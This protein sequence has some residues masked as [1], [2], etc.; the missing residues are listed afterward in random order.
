M[1]EGFWM[2]KTCLRGLAPSLV[3]LFGV[4]SVQA[5]PLLPGNVIIKDDGVAVPGLSYV[6]GGGPGGWNLTVFDTGTAP[7]FSFTLLVSQSNQGGGGPSSFIEQTQLTVA[8]KTAGG[9]IFSV[10]L[11]DTT[12][13]LPLSPRDLTSTATANW[14]ASTAADTVSYQGWGSTTNGLFAQTTPTPLQLAVSAGGAN[15]QNLLPNPAI[16]PF[17]GGIPF[18]MTDLSVI[19]MHEV[20]GNVTVDA[21][22]QVNAIVPEPASLTV[23]CLGAA[24]MAGYRLMRQRKQ[25]DLA[26]TLHLRPVQ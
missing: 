7:D 10:E 24:G 19:S 25:V 3:F 12:F 26:P 8:Q 4:A 20:G 21:R 13:L 5:G 16:A 1:S 18:S 14:G 23:L 6:P 15:S 22:T 2:R 17:P 11:S 9:H